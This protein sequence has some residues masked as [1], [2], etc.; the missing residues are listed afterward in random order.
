MHRREGTLRHLGSLARLVGGREA[1]G[2]AARGE[3]RSS[4]LVSAAALL[5]CAGGVLFTL[6]GV[7]SSPPLLGVVLYQAA[8]CVRALVFPLIQRY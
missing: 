8:W 2:G 6:T 3:R 1:A 4:V 7:L 5:G